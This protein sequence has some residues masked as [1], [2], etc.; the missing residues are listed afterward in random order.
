MFILPITSTVKDVPNKTNQW[1]KRSRF[2]AKAHV[3]KTI[4]RKVH[5]FCDPL[6]NSSI[7]SIGF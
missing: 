3:K 1:Y 6:M 2:V 4:V 7:F 5:I